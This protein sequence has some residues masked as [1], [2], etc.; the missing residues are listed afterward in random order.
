[1]KYALR[2]TDQVN[3]DN[4]HI[5]IVIDN[6]NGGGA[7]LTCLTIVRA[8]L[9]RNYRVDLVL[10]GY[11]GPRLMDIPDGVKLF[12]LDRKFQQNKSNERC[13]IPSDKIRWISFPFK[14]KELLL[15]DTSV[16][17]IPEMFK[18][19]FSA[20]SITPFL[21]VSLNGTIYQNGAT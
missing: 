3:K 20:S 19:L 11:C 16:S 15:C 17:E 21:L 14:V 9:R 4:S 5:A 7:E 18:F 1:M 2:Y 12:V 10:L 6:M 8:L 13:S